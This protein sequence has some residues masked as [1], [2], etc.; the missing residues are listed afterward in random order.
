MNR[1]LIQTEIEK[2]EALY[3]SGVPRKEIA[4]IMGISLAT[5]SNHLVC[6]RY[7]RFT[8]EQEEYI[9]DCLQKSFENKQKPNFEKIAE[10]IGKTVKNLMYKINN[11][12]WSYYGKNKHYSVVEVY[13]LRIL[14]TIRPYIKKSDKKLLAFCKKHNRIPENILKKLTSI[15]RT[16]K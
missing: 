15:R 1:P 7:D 10:E 6:N 8:A 3:A 5:I 11:R 4:E 9:Q 13:E 14:A 16:L 2:L 12:N